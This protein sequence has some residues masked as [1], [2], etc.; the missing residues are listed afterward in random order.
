M[1]RLRR[2]AKLADQGTARW[3]AAPAP[4]YPSDQMHYIDPFGKDDLVT[5]RAIRED[6]CVS[7]YL[8]THRK[9][10]EVAQ[11]PIRLKNLIARAEEVLKTRGARW[12]VI[13]SILGEAKQLL[14]KEFFWQ[15]QADGLAIF[16][17]PGET[18]AFRTGVGFGEAV[19]VSGRFDLAQ[20][21]RLLASD[22]RFYV[23]ALGEQM[24]KL[25]EGTRFSVSEIALDN[26]PQSIDDAL[27]LDDPQKQLQYHT[28][29]GASS[30]GGRA[31][32]FHGHRFD[33]SENKENLK[34][35]FNIVD[36]GL[37][38]LFKHYPAPVVLAAVEY[39]FPLYLEVANIPGLVEGGIKGNPDVMRDEELHKAAWSIVYPAFKKSQEDALERYAQVIGTGQTTQGVEG[40]AI[41]AYQ[42]RV[43][44]LFVDTEPDVWGEIDETT[45]SVSIHEVENAGDLEL[46]NETTL[47]VLT[48]G[49]RVFTMPSAEVPG[50]GPMAAILRYAG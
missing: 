48:S 26:L 12:D 18:R 38:P 2:Y 44:T 43:D 42:G 28:G 4:R 31:A 29:A 30:G 13:E 24:V 10:S 40:T 19:T 35:F 27:K 45:Q 39:Y 34:R 25:L 20:M 21:V 33:G 23:L 36:R 11:D 32:I 9:G 15:H 46:V 49:G 50:S 1:I 47:A 14:D 3:D 8:P 5:L 17:K 16:A 41:A 7:L 6:H 37:E 22:G